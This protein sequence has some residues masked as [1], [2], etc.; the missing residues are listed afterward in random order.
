[1]VSAGALAILA[2]LS[3]PLT[4]ALVGSGIIVSFVT[5]PLLYQVL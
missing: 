1:M 4:T 5:L 2:D 3:P